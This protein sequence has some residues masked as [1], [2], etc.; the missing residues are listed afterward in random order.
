MKYSTSKYDSVVLFSP[1]SL[2]ENYNNSLLKDYGIELDV[3][4]LLEKYSTT[5]WN[6]LWYFKINNLDYDFMLPYEQNMEEVTF[7]INQEVTTSEIYES[8]LKNLKTKNSEEKDDILKFE[9]DE[10]KISHFEFKV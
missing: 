1:L 4:Q 7:N 5:F 3:E 2:K 10:L 8:Q 9:K 6:T